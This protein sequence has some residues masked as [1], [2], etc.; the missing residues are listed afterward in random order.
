MLP[1]SL[2]RQLAEIVGPD[3]LSEETAPFAV[4]GRAPALV[5]TPASAEDL[6]RAVAACHAARVPLVP[7]GGGTRQGWGRP[8][9]AETFVV[10]RTTGLRSILMYEPDDLTISV[11]AG[12][13][14]AALD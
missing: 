2:T 5:I 14:F 12:M 4:H 8:I 11:E 3:G 7:W 13:T 6:A 10:L 9:A 1:A